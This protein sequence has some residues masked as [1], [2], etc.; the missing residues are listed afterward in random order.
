MWN[1]N[2]QYAKDDIV[3]YFKTESKQMSPDVEKREFAFV[4]VST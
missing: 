2:F 4:L 1:P 3:L